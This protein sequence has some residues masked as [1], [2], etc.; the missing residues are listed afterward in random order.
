[1]PCILPPGLG[2]FL[3]ELQRKDEE[4]NRMDP[5]ELELVSGALSPARDAAPS[6][7]KGSF[8][9]DVGHYASQDFKPPLSISCDHD[10]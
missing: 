6:S 5:A 4:E 9:R 7:R 3:G 1:M 10:Y 2:A 8:K